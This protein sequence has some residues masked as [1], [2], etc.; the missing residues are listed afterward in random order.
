MVPQFGHLISG[1]AGGAGSLGASSA[2][3]SSSGAGWGSMTS[4]AG[5]GAG[6]SAFSAFGGFSAFSSGSTAGTIG[7]GTSSTLPS[8][9]WAIFSSASPPSQTSGTA[10]AE[11][12]SLL[13]S[14]AS[15]V[16]RASSLSVRDLSQST[17]RF[18]SSM[19]TRLPL[20]RASACSS[21]TLILASIS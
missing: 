9:D 20:A 4:G 2:T 14:T 5:C 10:G 12:D 19:V 1:G 8:R 21:M 15:R 13:I 16:V 3:F 11:E 18:C 17:R 6:S 7:S